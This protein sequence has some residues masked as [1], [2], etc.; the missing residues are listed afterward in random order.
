MKDPSVIFSTK[1]SVTN[2][3]VRVSPNI[4]KRD[5]ISGYDDLITGVNFDLDLNRTVQF[6]SRVF[7]EVSVSILYKDT[8]NYYLQNP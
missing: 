3:T 5:M 8:S 7:L 1:C 4:L 2:D 6:Y